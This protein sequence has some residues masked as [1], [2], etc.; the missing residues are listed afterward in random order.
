MSWRMVRVCPMMMSIALGAAEARA[1]TSPGHEGG[2]AA[3]AVAAPYYDDY[4]STSRPRYGWRPW[5]G[6]YGYRGRYSYRR[7]YYRPYAPRY[8]APSWS[9]PRRPYWSYRAAPYDRRNYGPY[10]SWG[11]W[12]PVE[13]RWAGAWR[14]YGTSGPEWRWRSW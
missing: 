7:P 11:G 5:Y 1:D 13:P 12:P 8:G 4:R 3:V 6:T 14:D 2:D 9:G 10:D